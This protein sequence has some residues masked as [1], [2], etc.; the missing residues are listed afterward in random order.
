MFFGIPMILHLL[1]KKKHNMKYLKLILIVTFG[2]IC[3]TSCA[4]DDNVFINATDTLEPG[5]VVRTLSFTGSSFDFFNLPESVVEVDFEIQAPEGDVV[6]EVQIFLDFQDNTFF[7]SEFNT[8]GTTGVDEILIQT[9]PA[10]ELTEGRFG[11]P[12]GG[13][14][15]TYQELLD[16]LGLE[17][18]LDT[19]FNSDQFVVRISVEL[20]DGRSFTN[21]GTNSPS[22]EDGF[23]LSP[24]RYFPTIIC[25]VVVTGDITID[26]EDSFGDGWN[27]AA[28]IVTNDGEES[29]YTL[30]DGGTGS[31]T[32]TLPEGSQNQSFVFSGGSFDEEVGYTITRV[33]DGR[34]LA[35]FSPNPP[36]GPPNGAISLDTGLNPCIR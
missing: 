22:L 3:T 34:E 29:S 25:P 20:A 21:L 36:D 33:S 31:V 16:A 2:F 12:S 19:V 32:F 11:F 15:Y 17:N 6:T 28:I 35:S 27:G 24:F 7:D 30:D 8:N 4:P 13:F 18:N 23:F 10:S 14:S 26:F 1:T 9:I 5:L